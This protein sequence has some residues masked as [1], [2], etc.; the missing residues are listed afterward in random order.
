M[1]F[2]IFKIFSGQFCESENSTSGPT[3]AEKLIGS[4][5]KISRLPPEEPF[6][7]PIQKNVISMYSGTG[8]VS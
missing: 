8:D 2:P 3:K 5:K 7:E 1:L 4:G 6:L